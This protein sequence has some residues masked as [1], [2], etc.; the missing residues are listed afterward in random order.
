MESPLFDS[1]HGALVFAFNF[2]T[3]CYD[4]PIMNRMADG[5]EKSGKGLVGLDGAAQAGFVLAEVKSMGRIS[6]AVI[7]ARIAPRSNPCECGASCC[8]GHKSNKT[9]VDAIAVLADHMRNTALAGCVCNGIMRR[10]YVV[11]HFTKKDQRISLESLAQKYDI[12]RHTVS[13]HAAKVSAYFAGVT[14][15]NGTPTTPGIEQSAFNAIQDRL[16]EIGMVGY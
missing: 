10:E 11:R 13:A 7:A 16:E 8:S 15:S 2:S 5:P 3:Q 9:W 6:E 4:R 1:A 14:R 12:D